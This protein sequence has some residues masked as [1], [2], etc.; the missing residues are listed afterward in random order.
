[1]SSDL[2]QAILIQ[3]TAGLDMLVTRQVQGYQF[4][5]VGN[6]PKWF[7]TFFPEMIQEQG[8]ILPAEGFS[9][10]E[11][12]IAD[13]EQFWQGHWQGTLTSGL[14]TEVL[15]S[16]Q[17]IPL[18]A[19]ALWVDNHRILILKQV[20]LDFAETVTLIQTGRDHQL[21]HL[22]ECKQLERQLRHSTFYDPLTG[23][24]NRAFLKVYL[25]Q[26]LERFRRDLS[27][28]FAGLVLDIDRLKKLN[29][30]L[31][32]SA[33]DQLLTA[34]AQRV[35]QCLKPGDTLARLGGDDFFILLEHL[36]DLSAAQ[37]LAEQIDT[38]LSVPFMLDTQSV[39]IE[40]SIGIA[41]GTS[42][43]EQPDALIRDAC[44]AMYQ[45]KAQRQPR[46]AVFDQAMHIQ[47]LRRLQLE[48]DLASA[49]AQHELLAYYQPIISLRTHQVVGF[50]ALARW[51]HPRYGFLSPTEFIPIAE[52]TGIVLTI[53][54]WMLH[55]TCAQIQQWQQ[56]SHL[57]L[58][59]HVNLSARQLEQLTLFHQIEQILTETHLNPDQLKLEITESMAL[60]DLESAVAILTQIK[61]L[62]IQICLDD[63][64]TGYAS[65]SYLHQLPVDQLK[66]DRSLTQAICSGSAAIVQSIITLAHAL[67]ID[68]IAEGVETQ[69]QAAQLQALSCEYAQGYLFSK[70]VDS[71][72]ASQWM[73]QWVGLTPSL[74]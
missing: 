29:M 45:A 53:G 71:Q 68:V 24:P 20:Q 1:M 21:S 73:A 31:G 51:H 69:E 44:T 55:E 6:L 9:F 14:W 48:H 3:L 18:Q 5:I 37:Q 28:R 33:G 10:L 57:P 11:H 47:V 27:Y 8:L 2:S 66:I 16:G 4:Q 52:E 32:Y 49:I 72:A 74:P 15:P 58:T 17:D 62:G 19:S 59:L 56:R 36:H 22:A 60:N 54:Q 30:R 35:K 64:G 43:H 61:D 65:L 13:A 23:L 70:P 34:I 63:F 26:A 41:I 38:A 46:Y 50:E 12:F 7:Q 40:V 25:T 42:L 67:Q 39:V